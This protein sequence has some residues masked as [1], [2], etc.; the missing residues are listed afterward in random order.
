[1]QKLG[2]DS[3]SNYQINEKKGSGGFG[4]VY[5]AVRC[6]DDFPVAL[7]IINKNKISKWCKV[8]KFI[9]NIFNK[10]FQSI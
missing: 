2:S 9:I 3:N 7:K 8:Q 1:M 10:N 5:A 4:V 6:K